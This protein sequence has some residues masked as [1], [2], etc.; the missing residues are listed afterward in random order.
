MVYRP[1]SVTVIAWLLIFLAV[2][3]LFGTA[4]VLFH[5]DE[6]V[7]KIM[8]QS[9]LPIAVQQGMAF[10]GIAVHLVC[11]IFML[12]G[13]NWARILFVAWSTIGLCIGLSTSPYKFAM[14]PS[15]IMLA[16]EAFFLF[17]PAANAFFANDGTSI[18][19]MPVPSTH[20]VIGIVF[21]VFAGF[22]FTCM[23]ATTLMTTP[24]AGMK[25]L[26]L[27]F[28]LLPFSICLAIG[29]RL[30]GGNWKV[31]VGTVFVVGSLCWGST[32]AM[33]VATFSRPEFRQSLPPGQAEH[34][35]EMFTDYPFAGI[36]FGAWLLLGIALI[37][38]GPTPPQAATLPPIMG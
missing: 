5:P 15:A 34:M 37:L 20:R 19:S 16:I 26:M 12:R 28:I 30:A 14:F 17:R 3:A 21:Y 33:M 24:G 18:D 9:S 36:W 11:G 7:Q 23:G 8:A 38:L 13:R 6:K 1:T 32:A 4:W 27:C 22:L 2:A 10:G 31:E 29:R 35:Q 25:M